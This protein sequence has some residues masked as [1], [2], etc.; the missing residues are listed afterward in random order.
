MYWNTEFVVFIFVI[1]L[2]ITKAHVFD[3]WSIF[4][5]YLQIQSNTHKND[6]HHIGV[7]GKALPDWLRS[8]DNI[9]YTWSMMLSTP[10]IQPHIEIQHSDHTLDFTQVKRC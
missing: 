6:Q 8:Q 1:E 4:E 3:I 10:T 7:T 9:F 2:K 5:K